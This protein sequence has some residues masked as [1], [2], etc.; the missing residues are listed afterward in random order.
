MNPNNK[1][2]SMPVSKPPGQQMQVPVQQ[3]QMQIPV[4]QYSQIPIQISSNQAPMQMPPIPAYNP[5]SNN[6]AYISQAPII[7]VSPANYSVSPG[8]NFM[9]SFG[10]PNVAG[11]TLLGKDDK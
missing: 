9:G 4:Q 8:A 6:M 2:V 7:G 10:A 3:Q 11:I 5:F 1:P